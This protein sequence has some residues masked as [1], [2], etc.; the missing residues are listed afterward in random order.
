MVIANKINYNLEIK[1]IPR[2]SEVSIKI[3][4]YGVGVKIGDSVD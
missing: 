2:I 3:F 1:F 4:K